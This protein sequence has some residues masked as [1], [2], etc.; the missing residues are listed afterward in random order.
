MSDR[1][2]IMPRLAEALGIPVKAL[3]PGDTGSDEQVTFIEEITEL[4]QAFQRIEDRQARRRCLSYIR[5]TAD[6]ASHR[7]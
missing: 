5:A 6:R 1:S 4:V 2:Q 3:T 7:R